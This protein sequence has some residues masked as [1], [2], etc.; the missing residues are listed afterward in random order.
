MKVIDGRT[1]RLERAVSMVE[2]GIIPKLYVRN[3]EQDRPHPQSKRLK[4]APDRALLR[5][6]KTIVEGA[7]FTFRVGQSLPP[8]SN[9]WEPPSV[10]VL[11]VVPPSG[12]VTGILLTG[13][14][15]EDRFG[16][17]FFGGSSGDLYTRNW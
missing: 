10:P 8:G 4:I 14:F 13:A 17:G 11:S 5:P 16:G 12:T 9:L 1:G 3:G 2:D 6:P 15:G 7:A